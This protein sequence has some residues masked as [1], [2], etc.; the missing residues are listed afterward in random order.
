MFISL[1]FCVMLHSE[2]SHAP[3]GMLH[4]SLFAIFISL[5]FCV[6]LQSEFSH[7]PVGKQRMHPPRRPSGIFYTANSGI[8]Q[9]VWL[10]PVGPPSLPCIDKAA[11]L[12]YSCHL[13]DKLL[14]SLVLAGCQQRCYAG[15]CKLAA[16]LGFAVNRKPRHNT[17][18][19]LS[20]AAM[21]L[22]VL[23]TTP[24]TCTGDRHRS[25]EHQHVCCRA[26]YITQPL[27]C[28]W[29]LVLF[30]LQCLLNQFGKH[31]LLEKIGVCLVQVPSAYV[32]RLDLIPDVDKGQLSVLVHGSAAAK[33]LKVMSPLSVSDA[34]QCESERCSSV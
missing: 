1:S 18:I 2:S 11:V 14:Y 33:G 30:K 23:V 4:L 3:V 10:E 34:A 17:L 31:K 6:I 25:H 22:C 9:T 32:E 5:T 29:C 12:S 7:A 15:L 24:A 27:L 20:L 8:W 26:V 21:L 16:R 19:C 28:C 13:F